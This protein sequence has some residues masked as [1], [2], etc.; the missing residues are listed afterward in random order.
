MFSR[1]YSKQKAALDK[2]A[3]HCQQYTGYVN[4]FTNFLK[5]FIGNGVKMCH[6]AGSANIDA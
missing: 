1:D 6:A 5:L 3:G 2:A 4:I